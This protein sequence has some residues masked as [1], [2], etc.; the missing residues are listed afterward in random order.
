[1]SSRLSAAFK[2]FSDSIEPNRQILSGWMVDQE[3]I[4]SSRVTA[5]PDKVY[6]RIDRGTDETEGDLIKARA[7]IR[8]VP[9]WPVLIGAT[10]EYPDQYVV[11]EIDDEAM[12]GALRGVAI[13]EPHGETHFW[14]HSQGGDDAIFLRLWQLY[15]FSV[16]PDSGFVVQ[17]FGGVYKDPGSEKHEFEATLVDLASY[18]PES[19]ARFVVV[20]LDLFNN[21]IIVTPGT[22]VTE[23]LDINTNAP[24]AP[25]DNWELALVRLR[26]IDSTLVHTPTDV[27]IYD[28]R[29]A[30]TQPGYSAEPLTA[31]EI[32]ALLLE[33][34]VSA[35]IA[36]QVLIL[37]PNSTLDLVD[38]PWSTS[39]PVAPTPRWH[40]DGP[41]AIVDEV[42]GIWFLSTEIALER[43]RAYI[44]NTGSSGST[45][46]NIEKSPSDGGAWSSIFDIPADRPTF[47]AGGDNVV[48]A[49]PTAQTLTA[50]VLLRFCIDQVAVDVA[51]VSIQLEGQVGS[52]VENMLPTMGVA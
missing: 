40:A 51:D 6:V 48:Y 32:Y 1:M 31:E 46:L 22:V 38:P 28:L 26:D 11:L 27:G 2:Q 29:F 9:G 4:G 35:G 41:L 52:S 47:V 10:R 25:S 34:V 42:D 45:V 3:G 23:L 21:S 39:E 17:V 33:A 14:G 8:A 16:W 44:R 30:G 24:T 18:K 43:V 7:R 20:S 50:G 37:Q 19:G 13:V 49:I 15:E 12:G 5:E 36:G